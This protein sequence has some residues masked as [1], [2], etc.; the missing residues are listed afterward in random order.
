MATGLA[1]RLTIERR[2]V[3]K[4]PQGEDVI[5]WAS[6]GQCWAEIKPVSGRQFFSAQGQHADVT[7]TIRTRYR[8][9][10]DRTMRLTSASAV[11]DL[12]AVIDVD[13]RHQWLE[14]QCREAR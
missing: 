2:V 9:D 8:D 14:I 7:H 10:I 6:I 4:S 12:E 13:L 3:T 1:H 11:Y 5:T